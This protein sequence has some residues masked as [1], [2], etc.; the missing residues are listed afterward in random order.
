[1][2]PLEW[3]V[4]AVIY[5]L[6]GT[7]AVGAVSAAPW[8]RTKRGQRDLIASKVALKPGAKVYDLGCGDGAVLFSLAERNPG[9]RAVGYEIAFL[10]LMIGWTTKLLGGARYR[11]VS[12][13]CRDLF[14]PSLS[15]ADTVFVFLLRDCYPRL[16]RKLGAELRDDAEVVVAAWPLPGLEPAR[17]EAATE[18]LLPM[19]FYN[20]AQLRRASPNV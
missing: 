3:A 10:P 14:G 12:L 8:V 20:G 2:S 6:V 15:D 19:Y 18:E 16:M 4:F 5:V 9:V 7:F 17:S 13:R 11:N 1:M